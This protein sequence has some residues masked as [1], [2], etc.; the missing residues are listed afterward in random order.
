MK[1]FYDRSDNG[2]TNLFN[3]CEIRKFIFDEPNSV[4]TNTNNYDHDEHSGY[5]TSKYYYHQK[6]I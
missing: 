2:V 6:S 3:L 1:I 4:D 5:S